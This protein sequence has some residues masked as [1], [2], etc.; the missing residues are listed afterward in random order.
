MET[1]LIIDDEPLMRLTL[2]TALEQ[3]GYAVIEA[4]D[5]NEGLARFE[6]ENPDLVLTDIIM[7]DREGVETIGV[8]KRARPQTPIIAMSGGGRLGASVFLD[9]A[10]KLGATRTLSK[11]IRN[12]DLQQ[13]VRESLDAARTARP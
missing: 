11:P 2:R 5:G 3:A 1:I 12:G 8:M 6:A 13:A 4:C 10:Q 9:L 7:P